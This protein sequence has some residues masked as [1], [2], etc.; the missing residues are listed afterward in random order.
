MSAATRLHPSTSDDPVIRPTMTLAEFPALPDEPEVDRFHLRGELWELPMTK[1]SRRHSG[2]KARIAYLLNR[3]R[4]DH[5]RQDFE[6]FSGEVGGDLPDQESDVG[7]VVA[8]AVAVVVAVTI[9][10]QAS[11]ESY[12]IGADSG[13]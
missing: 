11:E 8:V 5:G 1:R 3:W 6:V 9:A 10:A 7:I 12:I 4:E 2:I 13:G